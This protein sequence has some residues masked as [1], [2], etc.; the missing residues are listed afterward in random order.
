ML[1]VHFCRELWD[2]P[3][4]GTDDAVQ[5]TGVD[6]VCAD[7]REQTAAVV[8]PWLFSDVGLHRG[9]SE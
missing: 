1:I 5:F 9:V 3:R 8:I 6:E 7:S 2:G 4:A